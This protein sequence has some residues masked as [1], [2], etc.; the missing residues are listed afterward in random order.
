VVGARET[1]DFGYLDVHRELERRFANYRYVT[2][3]TRESHN[4]DSTH[5]RF[6]G[7]Q[8]VQQFLGGPAWDELW[9]RIEPA[10]THV[11]ACGNPQMIGIPRVDRQGRR[12][13]P[14]PAGLI[15][16]LESRGFRADL[17]GGG[18]NIHFEKYW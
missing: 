5:P 14:R 2:L 8:Y 1:A 4:L 17:R 15:E 10:N 6:V 12:M 7:K 9:G 11:F 13:Y 18:G 3:T 16:I